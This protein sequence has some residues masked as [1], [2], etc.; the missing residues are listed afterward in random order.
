MIFTT[1]WYLLFAVATV[2]GFWLLRRAGVRLWFLGAACVVFHYHFAG[3][4]GVLPII[5]L[6]IIT[7]FAGLSRKPWAC[8]AGITA[9]VAAL[10]F[11]KYSLFLLGELVAP[12]SHPLAAWL[13]AGTKTVMPGAPPLGI[14]FFTFEFVHYL[15]EVKHG[16][17]PIR[18]PLKFLLFAIF[19]PSLVAGPIKRYPQ[20][21]PSLLEGAQRFSRES[22]AY[23]CWRI[24]Q[25]FAK[26][27]I[28][29]DNLTYLIDIYQ[30]QFATLSLWGRWGI[31]AAIAFRIL[32]DF[33][34]YSD[35]AIGCARLLGVRLPENFNWPYA[36]RN[37]QDFWQRW[38][39]SLSTW[40]RDYVYIPL[41]GSRHGV[42]RRICNGLLAF[43]LCG[44]WHGPA[45]HFVLWGLYHGVGLVICATYRR[46]PGLGAFFEKVFTKEPNAA[47]LVTQAYAWFGWLI[48]FYP[49]PEALRMAQLLFVP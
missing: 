49:V 11:Y 16:G 35:I 28:I 6:M 47:W 13:L 27:I 42:V 3:P 5:V 2:M 18:H 17:E 12:L 4:A 20:F 26:K 44:L 24:A 45:W 9:C 39:I 40:I 1:Y 7:F 46:V 32:M 36:A 15:Y 21:L 29:A 10:C 23:G 22:L 8:V 14:S 38:H 41:G 30:P 48:F 25:G 37:I 43:A 34:G 31:F 19:F 33:S